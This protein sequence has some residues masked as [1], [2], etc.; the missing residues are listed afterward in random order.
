MKKAARLAGRSGGNR[1]QLEMIVHVRKN[2]NQTARDGW[3]IAA[4]CPRCGRNDNCK[5][6]A[7]GAKLWCGR[8]SEGSIRENAGGQYLHILID[9]PGRKTP[10]P[11]T[12]TPT[13]EIADVDT[14]HEVYSALLAEIP[15]SDAHRQN[16]LGRKV[17]QPFVGQYATLPLNG[18]SRVVRR[19]REKFTDETLL[20][21][22]GFIAKSGADGSY[23]TLAGSPGML[24]AVRDVQ[25]RI[26]GIKIRSDART[27]SGRYRWLSSRKHGGPSPT[28]EPHVPRSVSGPTPILRMTCSTPC[29]FSAE[30]LFENGTESV[31]VCSTFL[32]MSWRHSF[33]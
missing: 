26:V 16:L 25:H 23:I 31:P 5:L 7:D 4:P 32:G 9:D 21:V 33:S 3:T 2:E 6:S 28:T 18:R 14:R 17:A 15:L 30:L 11:V 27:G 1:S 8:V 24:I 12:A 10:K 29:E 20:T 22:P 19:L 13:G